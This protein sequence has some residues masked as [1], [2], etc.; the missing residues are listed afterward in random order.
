MRNMTVKERIED[1][2]KRCGLSE[3][4]IRRV[5][6]A[7]QQSIADSLKRGERATLIG[8]CTIVPEIR[9]RLGVGGK[10]KKEI[11]LSASVAHS[12]VVALSDLEDFIKDDTEEDSKVPEGVMVT[13]I[14][15][16][17]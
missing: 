12:L 6:Q 15:G 17:I 1:I 7:E 10:L 5:L 8:R 14:T 11:K 4:I 16:L 13:Q 9:T 2:S 3:D